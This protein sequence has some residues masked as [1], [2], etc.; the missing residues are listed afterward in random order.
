MP[1]IYSA[2][3]TKNIILSD[4]LIDLVYFEKSKLV[5]EKLAFVADHVDSI[6]LKMWAQY[7]TNVLNIYM[8]SVAKFSKK[9][10]LV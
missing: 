10:I 2:I 1:W 4:Y 3:F 7:L 8:G 6:E 5:L 9:S